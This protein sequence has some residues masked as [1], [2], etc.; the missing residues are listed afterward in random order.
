MADDKIASYLD[1]GFD[2]F[3]LN[4]VTSPAFSSANLNDAF[5]ETSEASIGE[6]NIKNLSVTNA[7]IQDLS[8]T[9]LLAGMITVS[10]DIGSGN[11]KM[12]GANKRITVNDGTNDRVLIGY[13]AGKF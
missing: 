5:F 7:K 10:F 8:V 12:D 6:R 1:L 13:L 4:V 9:K 3:G 2:V 11:I